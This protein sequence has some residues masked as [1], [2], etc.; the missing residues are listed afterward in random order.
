VRLDEAVDV[1][2]DSVLNINGVTFAPEKIHRAIRA[3]LSRFVRETNC[4]KARATVAIT[5]STTEYNIASTITDFTPD[6][7]L[8][9]YISNRE[10]TPTTWRSLKRKYDTGSPETG[11]P[12]E[13]AFDADATALVWPSPTTSY[14]LVITYRKPLISFT[15]GIANNPTINIPDE[16]VYDAIWWG[17]RSYLIAGAPGHPDGP[18]AGQRFDALIAQARQRFNALD[19]AVDDR[20]THPAS[21]PVKAE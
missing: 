21:K 9:A 2:Q 1:L 18:E 3:S 17:G 12:T 4:S 10:V 15:P 7:F 8:W 11:Q 6:W 14:S 19:G 16:W 20:N 13:I 5:S